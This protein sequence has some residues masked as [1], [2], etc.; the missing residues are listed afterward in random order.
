MRTE[1]SIRAYDP[2]PS[3]RAFAW[4]VLE[5]GNG[6]YESGIYSVSCEDKEQ[7]RSLMLVHSV[8]GAPLIENWMASSMVSF[9]CS[10]AAPRSMYRV[11]HVSDT[12]EQMVEWSRDDLGEY[13]MFTPLLVARESIQHVVAAGADGLS[14]IWDGRELQ[15]PK[16]ARIAVGPTFKL[17]S[18]LGGLLEFDF[19]DELGL[20]RFRIEPSSEDGFKFKVYLATDLYEHLR[21]HRGELAGTNIMVH[22]VSAAFG[23]LQRDYKRDEDDDGESWQSFRNLVGLSDLLEKYELGHWS[24]DNFA[25]EMAATGLYPHRLLVEGGQ[26]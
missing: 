1:I 3:S 23:I 14:S 22:V 26:R 24:D 10:V 19:D 17:Q 8:S 15:L 9:V 5:E 12:P 21:Y 2:S 11:L 16:A 13:P 18:G 7:G 25:P 20:G 4:P 6:S